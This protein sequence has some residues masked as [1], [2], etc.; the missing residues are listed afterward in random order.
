MTSPESDEPRRI[1][2]DIVR[3]TA[4]ADAARIVRRIHT[5]LDPG[6]DRLAV[7]DLPAD[8]D[9]GD[10]RV[11]TTAGVIRSVEFDEI[12]VQAEPLSDTEAQR[13]SIALLDVKL[14]RVRAKRAS[15]VAELALIDRLQPRPNTSPLPLRPATFLEG[16]DLVDERRRA[17]VYGVRVLDYDIACLE[18]EIA[19][20]GRRLAR[21]GRTAGADERETV[22]VV[23]VELTEAATVEIEVSYVVDWATW[24]P[25]YRLR[26]TQSGGSIEC[27]RF[28]DLWQE[29]G[30]DWDDVALA[31]STAEPVTNLEL[32]YVPPWR[33]SSAR[34]F[35]DRT[36]ALYE[37]P[38]PAMPPSPSPPPSEGGGFAPYAAQFEEEGIFA[39]VTSTGL[40]PLRGPGAMS[41]SS[42]WSAS[43]VTNIEP[44]PVLPSPPP[45]SQQ[46][47]PRLDHPDAAL[48]RTQPD[49]RTSSGGFD[50]EIFVAQSVS[51]PS[52]QARS[53]LNLGTIQF[54]AK[55]SYLMRP[56]LRPHAFARVV[57]KN[58]EDLPLLSGPAA[59]FVDEAYFGRTKIETTAAGG[60][61]L[62]DLGAETGLKCARRSTTKVRTAGLIAKEDVHQVEV[63]VEIENHLARRVTI[64]VED[65]IPVS[66]ES[67]I[68]VRMVETSPEVVESDEL[69]GR[70]RFEV[71]VDAG[72]KVECRLRYEIASPR[73]LHIDQALAG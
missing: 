45:S 28:A 36:A 55:V 18:E 66:R 64:D 68:R 13:R 54:P 3:V 26:L 38:R 5:Q 56:A 63:V 30:E 49:P 73:D 32:P 65:Q 46:H 4:Y 1:S 70:V 25:F 15:L 57:A 59:I 52:R 14:R 47:E 17:T 34:A 67:S 37:R 39:D 69:T 11:S 58:A 31:L 33:L 29:T 2:S 22:L 61:L 19:A 8:L 48:F 23:A 7:G 44:L 60:T 10:L 41:E 6:V 16:L 72:Q 27:A 35:D 62:L 53:R 42:S 24:R 9:A 40:V 12:P 21:T 50:F 20:A 71:V 43:E 51:C